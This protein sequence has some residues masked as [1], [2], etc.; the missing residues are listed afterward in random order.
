MKMR[1]V[2]ILLAVMLCLQVTPCFAQPFHAN[3]SGTQEVPPVVSS[4]T[5]FCNALRDQPQAKLNVTCTYQGLSSPATAAHIHLGP[6]GVNGPV[7]FTLSLAPSSPIVSTWSGLTPANI[8]D[9]L[10]GNFYVNI[11]TQ[12]FPGGEIRGQLLSGEGPTPAAVPT[13]NGW[14]I[15]IFMIFLLLVSLHFIKKQRP[16]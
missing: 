10:A 14:G 7:V 8:A 15:F 9:L 12:V 13:M 11:H 5:G 6:P 16:T 2:L 3:L 1:L 4:G